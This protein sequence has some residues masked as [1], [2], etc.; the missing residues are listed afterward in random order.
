M[1]TFA[2]QI[3]ILAHSLVPATN[4]HVGPR[5]YIVRH[6]SR[7]YG[8]KLATIRNSAEESGTRGGGGGHKAMDSSRRRVLARIAYASDRCNAIE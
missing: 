8:T 1:Q 7:S 2:H 3:T 4:H 6:V 5:S